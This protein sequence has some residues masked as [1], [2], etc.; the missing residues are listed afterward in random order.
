[1][2]GNIQRVG[3]G[4]EYLHPHSNYRPNPPV[5]LIPLSSDSTPM[6]LMFSQMQK[7]KLFLGM[8]STT[9]IETMEGN[10]K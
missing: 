6:N 5:S 10:F 7:Q 2:H 1:M 4:E 9:T 8:L 3:G